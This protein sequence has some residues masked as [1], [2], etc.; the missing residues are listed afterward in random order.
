MGD[1]GRR[2]YLALNLFLIRIVGFSLCV[3]A[4]VCAYIYISKNLDP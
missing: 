3:C 2:P 1:E 4:Q